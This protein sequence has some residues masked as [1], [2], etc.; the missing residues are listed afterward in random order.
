MVSRMVTI[1]EVKIRAVM[2]TCMRKDAG[3]ELG[4]SS[5]LN[6]VRFHGECIDERISSSSSAV[7]LE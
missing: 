1:A 2:A 3:E 4:C 7:G 5:R 6:S